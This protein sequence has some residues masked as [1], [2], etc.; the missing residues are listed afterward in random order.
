MVMMVRYVAALAPG[1]SVYDLDENWADQLP[2]RV[3]CKLDG[4]YSP[5][6]VL[7]DRPKC[8]LDW[9]AIACELHESDLELI[10][11]AED[12]K[13]IPPL[14]PGEKYVGLWVECF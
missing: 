12:L 11:P 8:R 4:W 10:A 2:D 9:G 3:E 7:A 6:S 14:R 5:P 13:K 1:M